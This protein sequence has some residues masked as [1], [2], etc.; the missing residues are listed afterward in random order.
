MV[1]FP[2]P[3]ESLASTYEHEIP[4]MCHHAGVILQACATCWSDTVLGIKPQG[5]LHASQGLYQLR[6]LSCPAEHFFLLWFSV[7]LANGECT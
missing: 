3:V 7:F 6:C 5:L 1:S 4:D 2:V